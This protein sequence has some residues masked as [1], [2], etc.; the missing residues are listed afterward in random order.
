MPFST[1]SNISA[2]VNNSSLNSFFFSN[3]RAMP[4]HL[5]KRNGQ[6]LVHNFCQHLEIS[7]HRIPH[8]NHQHHQVPAV[9]PCL[10][11]HTIE[12]LITIISIIKLLQYH[13][14]T[15]WHLTHYLDSSNHHQYHQVLRYCYEIFRR[16][17]DNS[18]SSLSSC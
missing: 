14:E 2:S 4:I 13:H 12:F 15:F 18:L 7:Y 17:I 1:I 8:H 6:D 5:L 10:K 11:S 9:S 16:Q 3:M